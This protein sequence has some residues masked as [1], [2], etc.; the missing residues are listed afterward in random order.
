MIEDIVVN[1]YKEQIKQSILKSEAVKIAGFDILI[2]EIK[3]RGVNTENLV[4]FFEKIK[5]ST[6]KEEL[7]ELTVDELNIIIGDINMQVTKAL[8]SPV[9]VADVLVQKSRVIAREKSP[10]GKIKDTDPYMKVGVNLASEVNK[11]GI[12]NGLSICVKNYCIQKFYQAS[13]REELQKREKELGIVSEDSFSSN[14]SKIERKMDSRKSK[15]M[16][17]LF[18][19]E[20]T[21]VS[22][23]TFSEAKDNYLKMLN[24][25]VMRLE[26]Y[27]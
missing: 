3:R 9:E 5:T 22:T 19:K 1:S 2:G 27:K 7:N 10:N 21:E 17:E 25:K 12:A 6:T 14:S 24:D 26:E 4:T 16:K 11:H 20:L 13:Y 8:I 18:G 23:I 15:T